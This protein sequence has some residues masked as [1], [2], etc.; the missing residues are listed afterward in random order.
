M[1]ETDPVSFY[2]REVSKISPLSREQ[3]LECIR[4][5]RA[6][7]EQADWASKQLLERTL[8]LVVA[9]VQ[10]HPSDRI[11]MLDLIPLGNSALFNALRA[12]EDS[13]SDDFSAFA[14]PFIENAIVHA[15]TTPNC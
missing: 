3:Q 1:Y 6:K 4:H 13:D 10:K 2:L 11:H 12:F 5:I 7:D 14:T 15:I 9:I 8:S